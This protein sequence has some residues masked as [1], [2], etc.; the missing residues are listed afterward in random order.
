VGKWRSEEV[1]KWR[2]GGVGKLRSGGGQGTIPEGKCRPD[3]TLKYMMFVFS[4]IMPSRRDY[5]NFSPAESLSE[6]SGAKKA[7]RESCVEGN[8]S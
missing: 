2:S 6:I 7:Q 3:G 1:K 4:T 8:H 5:Y